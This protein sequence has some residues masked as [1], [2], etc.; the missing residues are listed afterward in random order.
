MIDG[1]VRSAYLYNLGARYL[2][3][4]DAVKPV[5]NTTKKT[6]TSYTFSNSS[7]EDTAE[8]SEEA[9]KLYNSDNSE[10]FE[11]TA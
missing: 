8:I 10:Q 6:N 4:A 1:G 2:V 3:N 5:D 9:L 11:D 7:H